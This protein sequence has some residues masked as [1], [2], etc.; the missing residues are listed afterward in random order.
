M[1]MNMDW[2][3]I[4]VYIELAFT[5]F[6]AILLVVVPVWLCLWLN[7]LQ[8]K[9][10]LLQ[11]EEQRKAREAARKQYQNMIDIREASRKYLKDLEEQYERENYYR[12]KNRKLELVPKD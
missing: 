4:L 11:Q 3:L 7:K 9:E 2:Q 6:V 1:G 12:R 5:P 10:Q 8:E